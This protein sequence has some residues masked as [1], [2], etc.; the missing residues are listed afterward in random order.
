MRKMFTEIAKLNIGILKNSIWKFNFSIKASSIIIFCFVLNEH[1][2]AQQEEMVTQFMYNKLSLNP[3]YA[4][5]D[6]FT[7]A[8]ILIRDQWNGIPGAPKTQ[9][10]GVNLPMFGDRYGLGF[11]IRHNEIGIF[12]NTT[13]NISYAYKIKINDE[14]MFSLGIDASGRNRKSD[15]T[16]AALIATQGIELDPSIPKT[17][18]SQNLFN[19]GSGVYLNGKR[20]FVGA[21]VPRLIKNNLDFDNN[22]RVSS[23]VRHLFMMGGIDFPISKVVKLKTQALIKLAE[24]SPFDAELNFTTVLDDKYSGGLTY[25]FGG[26]QGDVA[27]SIDIIFGFNITEQVTTL[28]SIDFTLSQIRKFDNG[29]LELGFAYAFKKKKKV[30]VLNPRYF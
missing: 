22:A 2:I 25:R 23:E 6:E 27:E 4:G 29:S 13:L 19:L 7:T 20:F 12:T 18:Q 28:F 10:L 30:V 5:H 15:F 26:G 24:N 21:A 3:A 9:I 1:A 17:A 11:N 14:T 16:N 8:S